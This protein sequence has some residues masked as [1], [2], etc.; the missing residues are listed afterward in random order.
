MI[1]NI[2][3]PGRYR[4]TRDGWETRRY[5]EE[6]IVEANSL[7]EAWEILYDGGADWEEDTSTFSDTD[8]DSDNEQFDCT[9]EEPILKSKEFLFLAGYNG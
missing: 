9:L 3:V 5:V 1:E 7:E 8:F 6:A 2:S 4:F